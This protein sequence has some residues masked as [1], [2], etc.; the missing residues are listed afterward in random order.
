MENGKI[1]FWTNS[2]LLLLILGFL[3]SYFEPRLLFSETTPTGGDTPSHFTAAA[4]FRSFLLRHFQITGWD[5][6]NLAGYPL[7][8][9][10]FPSPFVLC[11]ILSLLLPMTVSFKIVSVLGIFLLPFSAFYF[12]KKLDFQFPVPILGAGS[13]LPFLFV[14]SQ[15]MWGGN[16]PSMLA[17]EFPYSLGMAIALVY[18][19]N[20]Y[21]GIQSGRSAVRNALLLALAGFSHGC[22]LLVSGAMPLFCTVQDSDTLRRV[23]YYVKV[24]ALAFL[25]LAFWLLPWVMSQ[26]FMSPFNFL[27]VFRSW[28]ELFP[29]VLLPAYLLASVSG[30]Y[31]LYFFLRK[32]QVDGRLLYLWFGALVCVVFFHIGYQLNVVDIRFIPFLQLFVTLI[33]AAFLGS[34]L[35]RI[36]ARWSFVVAAVLLGM[37]WSE[38]NSTTIRNWIKWNYEGFEKKPLWPILHEV[39]TFLRGSFQSP[40]VVY[41][42]SAQH[43]Q[44]GSIRTFESLPYL[45]DRATLEGAYLQSSINSPFIFYLQSEVSEVTS[46][47]LPDYHCAS[48]DLQRALPQLRLFNAGQLILRSDAAKKQARLLPEL[49]LEKVVGPLEIYRIATNDGHYVVPLSCAPVLYTGTQWKRESFRWYRN[50]TANSI[51]VVMEQNP[52]TED[53]R[54]FSRITRVFPVGEQCMPEPHRC[55]IQESI[56]HDRIRIRSSCIG[57]PLLIKVTYHPR[58]KVKGAAKVYLATPGFMLIFPQ[59][60]DVELRFGWAGP[61]YLGIV[62][63]WFGILLVTFNISFARA[64][65]RKLGEAKTDERSMQTTASPLALRAVPSR[66]RLHSRLPAMARWLESPRGSWFLKISIGAIATTFVLTMLLAVQRNDSNILFEKGLKYYFVKDFESAQSYFRQAAETNPESSF[67]ITSRFYWGLCLYRQNRYQ[68]TIEVFRTLVEQFPE[69]MY[70]PEAMYHIGLSLQAKGSPEYEKYFLRT[71][72][73]Y[74]NASWAQFSRERLKEANFDLGM[75]HFDHQEFEMAQK[76][77]RQA[78]QDQTATFQYRARSQYFVAICDF[79]SENWQQAARE[80]K[81]LISAYPDS[82]WVAEALYHLGLCYT[83]LRR[84]KLAEESF[85]DVWVRFP[86]TRW[87]GYARGILNQQGNHD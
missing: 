75:R 14:E 44:F 55:Q 9:Y 42:H 53:L 84:Q 66:L 39:T 54:H 81:R 30:F 76:Y 28:S 58:W 59:S 60:H 72:Q 18:L 36:P 47:P 32:K 26:N 48:L 79:K 10:Y 57:H 2:I 50:Y 11:A 15:S 13:M 22:A 56:E 68:E 34:I 19:S 5:Y 85:R 6:G 45:S 43:D 46:C 69:S 21:V 3:L 25:F 16:I 61:N 37:V 70:T 65:G 82:E 87:A 4:L 71:I 31:S 24:H 33:G 77:F 64:R 49:G 7:F 63:T 35:Q 12:L 62:S 67:G 27:W 8:Q 17:G 40:R 41:E 1:R 38:Y 73:Q 52:A 20:F 86:K 51:P 29:R 78:S 74:P 80:F 83:R 23:K